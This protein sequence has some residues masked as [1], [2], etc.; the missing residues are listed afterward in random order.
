[1]IQSYPHTF[2]TAKGRI[3]VVENPEKGKF[4]LEVTPPSDDVTTV[5]WYDENYTDNEIQNNPRG[6]QVSELENDVLD[7]FWNE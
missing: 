2:R 6:G 4:V 3:V 1:M 7:A 5:Y